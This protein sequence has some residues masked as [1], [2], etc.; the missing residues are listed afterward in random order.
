MTKTTDLT[1]GSI[2]SSILGFYFPM[3]LTNMLQQ[4][5]TVA[6]TA[7]VGKGLGDDKLGAVGNMSSLTFLIFGF[8]TGLANGF[9]VIISQS[10]GARNAD[11]LRKSVAATVKL[12]IFFSVVLTALSVGFLPNLLTLIQTDP[13]IMKDGLIYG[14]II[15]GGL[16]VTLSYNLCSG[17]LRALGDSKTPFFAIIVSSVINVV[18]DILLIFG[19][20]TGVEG[21]AIATVVSQVASTLICFNKIR[22]IDELRF[23]HE[24]FLQSG[25]LIGELISNGLPMALMNSITAIGCIV[26]QYFVNGLGLAYT[27]AYS[28]YSKFI[29]LFSQPACTAGFTISAFTSQNYGAKEYN[30]IRAGVKV[31]LGIATVAYLVLGSLMVFIPR[32]LALIMLNGDEAISL[33]VRYLIPSG[34]MI[35]AVDYLFIF[36][37]AVQGMGKPVIPMISGIAE[38][39]IRVVVVFMLIESIGFMS[40]AYAQIAAW[41]GALIMNFSAY[42]FYIR[43]VTVKSEHRKFALFNKKMKGQIYNG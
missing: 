43:K 27:E 36:R 5:Y 11:R 1:K 32:Q 39:I 19:F 35:F 18:L 12:F 8:A 29:N 26:L 14:Y 4:L 25:G 24:D 23:S 13:S 33:T 7:I 22:N 10:F 17:I 34:M 31:C 21:A 2:T 20:K 30:R 3:L 41:V 42:V 15:F 16:I 38:M 6:D 40:T 28:A 9:S 37:S